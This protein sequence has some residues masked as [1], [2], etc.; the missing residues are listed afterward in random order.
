MAWRHTNQSF[1]AGGAEDLEVGAQEPVV[2]VCPFERD[3]RFLARGAPRI[4]SCGVGVV[5]PVEPDALPAVDRMRDMG[6]NQAD[7]LFPVRRAVNHRDE[8][9]RDF[10]RFT[11]RDF[12][13]GRRRGASPSFA[14]SDRLSL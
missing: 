13:V 8:A 7:A 3:Q 2:G 9:T 14:I 10:P 11:G 12:V 4:G 1:P 5:A 6:A